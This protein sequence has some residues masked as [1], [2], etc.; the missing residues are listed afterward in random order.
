MITTETALPLRPQASPAARAFYI[1]EAV[2]MS[3]IV[4]LGFWPFYAGLLT[5][6]TSLHPVMY[7]H[8]AVFT[9]WLIVLTSQVVLV[10]RRKVSQH[11]RVGTFGAAYAMLVLLLGAMVMILAPVQHVIAGEWTLDAA[12]G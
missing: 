9:G 2:L 10:Y 5:G 1:G 6:S 7:V 8:A 12:A 4:L 3:G 11:R